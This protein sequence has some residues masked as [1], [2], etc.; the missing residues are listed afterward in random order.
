MI[1]DET[2]NQKRFKNKSVSSQSDGGIDA[3]FVDERLHR[4][5]ASDDTVVVAESA[6]D[7]RN[8]EQKRLRP[9]FES[10]ESEKVLVLS[11]IGELAR[12]FQFHVFRRRRRI[13]E[14]IDFAGE[15]ERVRVQLRLYDATIAWRVGERVSGKVSWFMSQWV[16]ESVG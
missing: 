16:N 12:R 2:L 5:Q 1:P 3:A 15:E 11:L 8:S 6:D 14:T 10:F 9:K 4:L 13:V 7:F